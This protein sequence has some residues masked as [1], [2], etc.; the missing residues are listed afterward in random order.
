MEKG[1]AASRISRYIFLFFLFWFQGVFLLLHDVL[2]IEP[3]QEQM[4]LEIA[5]HFLVNENL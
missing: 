3:I 4:R 5:K 1:E 2:E